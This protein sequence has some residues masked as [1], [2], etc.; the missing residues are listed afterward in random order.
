VIKIGT[1][2]L[3]STN[4][5]E[6]KLGAG[7]A[8]EPRIRRLPDY[9]PDLQYGDEAT[10]LIKEYGNDY[11][12]A[13]AQPGA[14]RLP[15]VITACEIDRIEHS[16]EETWI[17]LTQYH[18]LDQRDDD[19]LTEFYFPCFAFEGEATFSIPTVAST[20]SDPLPPRSLPLVI[21]PL[22][23]VDGTTLK[24]GIRISTLKWSKDGVYTFHFTALPNQLTQ[25]VVH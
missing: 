5:K 21:N 2:K 17:Y 6:L 12:V 1:K 7:L 13:H 14:R 20:H 9:E 3:L 8:F 23:K 22:N 24:P 18:G 25:F 16:Q 11:K 10:E 19:G 15:G 4:R